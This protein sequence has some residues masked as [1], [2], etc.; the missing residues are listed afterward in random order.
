[1]REM[2]LSPRSDTTGVASGQQ[3]PGISSR[4]LLVVVA[5][6]RNKQLLSGSRPRIDADP[7]KRRNTSIALEEVIR[8]LVPFTLSGVD[9][10]QDGKGST[11]LSSSAKEGGDQTEHSVEVLNA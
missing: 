2:T 9:G 6:L 1:M 10:T 7:R 5:T 4:F 3:W 11:V 8:G